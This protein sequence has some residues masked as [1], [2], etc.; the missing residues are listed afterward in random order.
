MIDYP[1]CKICNNESNNKLLKVKEMYFGT[2]EVFDYL[3][4]NNCG[5]LQLLTF[6]DDFS[7]H[8]PKGYFTFQQEHENKIKSFLNGFRD[9]AAIGEYSFLGKILLN[10]FGEPT[11]IKRLKIAEVTLSDRILDVGCGKGILLHKMKES[12]FKNVL[13]IDPFIDATIN[14]KNG[15]KILKQDFDDLAGEFDFMMFN[16]SFEHMN[17]PLKIMKHAN[18]L[19]MDNKFLLLRIPVA[20]SFAFRKYRENWCSLDSPRHLFIHTKESIKILADKSG[21]EIVKIDYDSRSWQLWG[22]EQYS[23]DIPLIDDRSYYVNPDKSIFTEKQISEFEE[24][25]IE[26][27]KNGVGDQAEFYLKKV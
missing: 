5:C 21:F 7:K 20:D 8:Y 23:I 27:N 6:P 11:Y 17:D 15:L 13:G 26:L 9:R 16:H 12:G 2:R 14:Y 4:C 18:K 25:T 1:A 24:K 22:S 3:E 19:L 10:Q